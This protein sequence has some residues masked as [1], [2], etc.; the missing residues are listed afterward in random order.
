[1]T[2]FASLDSERDCVV[3]IRTEHRLL[4]ES[5]FVERADFFDFPVAV[6][7]RLRVQKDENEAA[8]LLD[9]ASRI[10]ELSIAGKYRQTQRKA[11][12]DFRIQEGPELFICDHAATA[13]GCAEKQLCS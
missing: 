6:V 3:S 2:A 12:S 10:Q 4:I 8:L 5:D 11:R 7:R 1:M 9:D 13:N